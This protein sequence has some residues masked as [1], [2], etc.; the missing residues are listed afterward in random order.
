MD[1]EGLYAIINW[2][3]LIAEKGKTVIIITHDL[4]LAEAIGNKFI[5]LEEGEQVKGI[6]FKNS[7]TWCNCSEN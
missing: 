6:K 7:K 3:K 1:G 5:Y 2:V 4:L